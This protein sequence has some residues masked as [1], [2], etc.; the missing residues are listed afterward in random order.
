MNNDQHQVGRMLVLILQIG[1]TMLTAVFMC[2]G[3]AY[4]I[5]WLF[6]IDLMVWLIILGVVSGFRAAY[7]LIKRYIGL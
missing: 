5:N 7:I 1:L 6:G 2:I 3:L 4:L